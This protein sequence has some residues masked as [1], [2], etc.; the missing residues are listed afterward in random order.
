[1]VAWSK[2]RQINRF[3]LHNWVEEFRKEAKPARQGC[4]WMEV[5][6]NTAADETKSDNVIPLKS[7]MPASTAPIRISIGDAQIEVTSSFE[8][9]ALSAVIRA[10]KSQC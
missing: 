6:V 2:E 10:V 3:T 5:S 7:I 8:E 4:E 9:N 1:M